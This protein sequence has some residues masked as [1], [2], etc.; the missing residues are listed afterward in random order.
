MELP[1][2]SGIWGITTR[3]RKGGERDLP[4]KKKT[5]KKKGSKKK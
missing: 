5:A 4:T 2:P 3:E 1:L